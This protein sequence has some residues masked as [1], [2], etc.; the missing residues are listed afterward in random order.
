[1]N[2]KEN[3][4]KLFDLARQQAPL[5][6]EEDVRQL[7]SAKPVA[8]K[9]SKPKITKTMTLTSIVAATVS[10][11]IVIF[12]TTKNH[13]A[14]T[15]AEK[16]PV[17]A[18]MPITDHNETLSPVSRSEENF[19]SVQQNPSLQDTGKK[20]KAIRKEYVNERVIEQVTPD[21]LKSN[22][23]YYKADSMKVIENPNV[24]NDKEKTRPQD[25]TVLQEVPGDSRFEKKLMVKN[26]PQ[27]NV[28]T[29]NPNAKIPA[30]FEENTFPKLSKTE[31][32]KLGIYIKDDVF[33]YEMKKTKMGEV[34]VSLSN[35]EMH[36][37]EYSRSGINPYGSQPQLVFVSDRFG[38]IRTTVYSENNDHSDA[39]FRSISQ[40][41]LPVLVQDE[42]SK[43][44]TAYIAWFEINKTLLKLLPKTVSDNLK[45][46]EKYYAHQLPEIEKEVKPFPEQKK[47][48]ENAPALFNPLQLITSDDTL[49]KNLGFFSTNPLYYSCKTNNNSLKIEIKEGG[50]FINGGAEKPKEEPKS[51]REVFPVYF[52]DEMFNEENIQNMPGLVNSFRT[53]EGKKGNPA[54]ISQKFLAERHK[55]IA[56]R[57]KMDNEGRTG[58]FWYEP[59]DVF[60]E[61][62]SDADSARIRAYLDKYE[63]ELDNVQLS[64]EVPEKKSF[65]EIVNP[66]SVMAPVKAM[67]LS[68]AQLAKLYIHVQNNEISHA[69]PTNS[70]NSAAFSYSKKGTRINPEDA[71]V[72]IDL[73]TYIYPEL[74][75]DD[76]GVYPRALIKC[77]DVQETG[78][79]NYANWIPVLV[80][81]GDTYTTLDQLEQRH[82][83]DLIFWYKPTD[84]FLAL[85][86]DNTASEI[87]KDVE[88]LNCTRSKITFAN[89]EKPCD[90]HGKVSCK[91]FEACQNADAKAISK[92]LV[93]PNPAKGIFNLKLELT[94]DCNVK[95]TFITLNGIEKKVVDLGP[96]RK[97]LE[98]KQ[99]T[100]EGFDPGIYLLRITTDKGDSFIERL[101]VVE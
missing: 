48:K 53:N 77:G 14:N 38:I 85:L 60:L 17:I 34:K 31:L 21:K 65:K 20:I 41:L 29:P 71:S 1:M 72:K 13:E 58:L 68:P 93:Y 54:S 15:P 56:L 80:R 24:V 45:A 25:M 101:I 79:I 23:I 63:Y 86:D 32:Q 22:T 50:L 75:T 33:M 83:P 6:K 3:L 2:Q 99:L 61:A 27:N 4:K 84:A 47:P 95:A 94:N 26:L 98:E 91:Y 5:L 74:I 18:E 62:L 70:Q 88:A 9:T 89:E 67:E 73:K 90:Q 97:G 59:F 46:N 19:T 36:Q 64:T 55:L 42:Q 87:R 96:V 10:V 12:N 66:V 35:A 28:Y 100:T 40:D 49:L 69:F 44:S 7:L 92:Y 57:V 8:V 16:I 30:G 11:A 43:N 76:L 81:S 52:T 37:L 51:I 39:H 78:K 82:R